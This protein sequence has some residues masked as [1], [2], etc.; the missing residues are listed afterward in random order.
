MSDAVRALSRTVPAFRQAAPGKELLG[1]YVVGDGPP[2][3][4]SA[5]RLGECCPLVI[6][7]QHHEFR[8]RRKH[9]LG[10]KRRRQL[11]PV[12]ITIRARDAAARS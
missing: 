3:S 1:G 12:A 8:L 10:S 9:R 5:E 11:V 6:A 4:L 7:A 2:A